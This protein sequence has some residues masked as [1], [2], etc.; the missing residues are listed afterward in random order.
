MK[1]EVGWAGAVWL[2]TGPSTD[3]ALSVRKN[4]APGG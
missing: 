3:E 1:M 4:V 2:R